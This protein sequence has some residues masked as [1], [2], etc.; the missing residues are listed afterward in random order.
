MATGTG[1]STDPYLLYT[2]ADLNVVRNNMGSHFKLMNDIVL[3]STISTFLIAGTFSGDFNGNGYSITN[4]HCPS[5]TQ[6]NI[7]VFETIT[8]SIYKLGISWKS[9]QGGSSSSLS[10]IAK[11]LGSGANVYEVKA[12]CLG[13]FSAYNVFGFFA[14]MVTGNFRVEN[15]YGKTHFGNTLNS[16]NVTLRLFANATTS[17]N[18][19]TFKNNVM[20][21]TGMN[22]N[23][24][25][26]LFPFINGS[27]S[28]SGNNF[29]SNMFYLEGYDGVYI[30]VDFNGGG[31][32]INTL[33]EYMM[34]DTYIN[35]GFN[36]TTIWLLDSANT[37]PILRAFIKILSK[38]EQR[39]SVTYLK[40]ISGK[41]LRYKRR[42]QSATSYA[43][44]V[45]S[46]ITRKGL[47]RTVSFA[48]KSFSAFSLRKK[49]SKIVQSFVKPAM[50]SILIKKLRKP[51]KIVTAY[52]MKVT[53]G[54]V[55]KRKA[56]KIAKG[57]SKKVLA[58]TTN[59]K[60][61]IRISKA[62]SK[63]IVSGIQRYASKTVKVTSHTSKITS[64]S[65]KTFLT[66]VLVIVTSHIEPIRATVK[67]FSNIYNFVKVT[68]KSHAN[69]IVTS[70][71]RKAKVTHVVASY[72]SKI[73]SLTN[74][75]YRIA[76][77]AN[78]MAIVRHKLSNTQLFKRENKTDLDKKK[79]RTTINYK[80]DGGEG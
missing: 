57:W 29:S 20:F 15:C 53:G 62:F 30:N 40:T 77:P 75:F 12:V 24:S 16:F 4:I 46:G 67:R 65:V 74:M 17:Y 61:V 2:E 51:M 21:V 14:S 80:D 63:R 78:V 60:R 72:A 22:Y 41:N 45:A 76:T 71:E 5:S 39:L 69:A 23:S 32:R 44:K 38:I 54:I 8:G 43:R 25:R 11:T 31:N 70:A 10:L 6:P 33:A 26:A 68:V 48:K 55:R 79:H 36:L 3:A 66:R 42:L 18:N 34:S 27:I 37:D 13:A 52:S 9:A 7:S 19:A 50:S 58:T 47:K 49:K 1:T 64:L 28:G 56:F 73:T 59:K 35:Y